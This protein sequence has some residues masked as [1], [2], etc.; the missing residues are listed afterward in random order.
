MA[1][2]A[3]GAK[4]IITSAARSDSMLMSN[5]AKTA[6][7]ATANANEPKAAAKKFNNIR[8]EVL[9]KRDPVIAPIAIIA[10]FAT[11]HGITA[12]MSPLPCRMA[13]V[14]MAPNSAVIAVK[15][16]ALRAARIVRKMI[17]Q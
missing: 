14:S 17:S 5:A 7:I 13:D 2:T 3:P 9:A 1:S 15:P 4:A 6:E 10:A 16:S 11:H 12:W 8:G